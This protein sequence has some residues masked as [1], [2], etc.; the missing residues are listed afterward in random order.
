[1]QAET[2][3]GMGLL[4]HTDVVRGGKQAEETQILCQKMCIH[5]VPTECCVV[6]SLENAETALWVKTAVTESGKSFCTPAVRKLK[7]VWFWA[8]VMVNELQDS[9]KN[10]TMKKEIGKAANVTVK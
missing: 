5:E 1:M 6:V 10:K 9:A 7:D 4:T 3:L 8:W 2:C